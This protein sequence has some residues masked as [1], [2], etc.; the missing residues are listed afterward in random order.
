M[1]KKKKNKDYNDIQKLLEQNKYIRET[2]KVIEHRRRASK[3][4]IPPPTFIEI[5]DIDTGEGLH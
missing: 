4:Y 3:I 2:K 5:Y 1:K